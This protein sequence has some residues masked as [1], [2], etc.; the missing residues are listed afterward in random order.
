MNHQIINTVKPEVVMHP[1]FVAGCEEKLGDKLAV[2]LYF[3]TE[4]FK[5]YRLYKRKLGNDYLQLVTQSVKEEVG[6]P[7]VSA[8]GEDIDFTTPYQAADAVH[9]LH[10][11]DITFT[12]TESHAP[13]IQIAGFNVILF[14]Y[15]YQGEYCA[16]F[17]WANKCYHPLDDLAMS[18]SSQKDFMSCLDL[19]YMVLR[20]YAL[21][22]QTMTYIDIARKVDIGNFIEVMLG[23]PDVI[24]LEPGKDT[25]PM[26]A[27]A[28]IA[29]RVFY[30]GEGINPEIKSASKIVY[31]WFEGKLHGIYDRHERYERMFYNNLGAKKLALKPAFD[32]GA[33]IVSSYT[34][35]PKLDKPT[36]V[37]EDQPQPINVTVSKDAFKPSTQDMISR[38][39]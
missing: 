26:K 6:S 37:N 18:A 24:D 20:Q 8:I 32:S 12:Y 9:L 23:L 34:V 21:L 4:Y 22:Q 11:G 28:N 2:G 33:N 7:C 16:N 13:V 15:G 19:P 3:L 30:E 17:E 31:E 14:G 25:K 36:A 27:L 10:E 5:R 1:F 38:W 29:A 39:L 35:L